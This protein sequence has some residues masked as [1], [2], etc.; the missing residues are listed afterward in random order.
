MAMLRSGLICVIWLVASLQPQAAPPKIDVPSMAALRSYVPLALRPS[1]PR[2]DPTKNGTARFEKI[3]DAFQQSTATQTFQRLSDVD[4]DPTAAEKELAPLRGALDSLIAASKLEWSLPGD[5]PMTSGL[6]EGRVKDPSD[7]P[8]PNFP[9]YAS[10][11][12]AVRILQFQARVDA[13][14]HR[15]RAVEEILAVERLGIQLTKGRQ[16]LTGFLGG[17]A[18]LAN[19][20][21]LV[22]ASLKGLSRNELGDLLKSWPASRNVA[23]GLAE[24]MRTELDNS[25]HLLRFTVAQDLGSTLDSA[26][27]GHPNPFDAPATVK[28][29]ASLYQASI[30]FAT[31]PSQTRE[32]PSALMGRVLQ[33]VPDIP[34][35]GD[36]PPPASLGETLKKMDNPLGKMFCK[37]TF[38]GDDLMRLVGQ[39]EAW[40]DSTRLAL[41]I[42]IYRRD[43]GKLPSVLSDL[44]ASGILPSLPLDPFSERPYGYDATR[45]ILWSIGADRHDDG[46]HDVP[47]VTKD[48]KDLVWA[49]DGHKEAR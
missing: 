33:G 31:H 34:G 42:E 15:P 5:D 20:H 48:A 40:L 43:K 28:L 27:A 30:D 25:L 23:G 7:F 21:A 13:L 32:K 10:L 19:G 3:S 9:F 24:T 29:E 17:T 6:I 22:F 8:S 4:K 37:L 16:P 47:G 1:L 18:P 11:R 38:S 45:A 44:V 49:L 2:V 35:T 46:G 26:L 41:A 39:S 14:R 12:N 36:T